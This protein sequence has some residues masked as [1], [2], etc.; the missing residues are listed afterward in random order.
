[1]LVGLILA[2]LVCSC[3]RREALQ[4]EHPPAGIP[5][6]PYWYAVGDSLIWYLAAD[7]QGILQ[8]TTESTPN[9]RSEALVAVRQLG[10]RMSVQRNGMSRAGDAQ[11]LSQTHFALDRVDLAPSMIDNY[12]A[13]RESFWRAPDTT[14]LALLPALRLQGKG[15]PQYF[16]PSALVVV[17][18]PGAREAE[19]R[20]RVDS[21]G[22]TVHAPL[23]LAQ[24]YW[25]ERSWTLFLPAGADLF[26]WL[27]WFNREPHAHVAYPLLARTDQPYPDPRIPRRFPLEP[28]S[29]IPSGVEKFSQP[30]R[31]AWEISTFC[32]HTDYVEDNA[33]VEASGG[34]L[35]V[36]F[37]CTSDQDLAVAI[38]DAGGEVLASTR[39]TLEAWVPYDKLAGVAASAAVISV[40]DVRANWLAD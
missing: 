2:S 33:S 1:M 12:G 28:D 7:S 22:L 31:M 11:E 14:L 10:W 20:A 17:W 18:R 34:R 27:R 39:N 32:G 9:A 26:T 30:L 8:M 25:V 3:S 36:I 37:K 6:T 35:R 40:E 29:L 21:L 16:W 23:G 5:D 4:Y 15:L 13:F 24:N 19:L 38:K